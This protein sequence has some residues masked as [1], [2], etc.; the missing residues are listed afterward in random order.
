MNGI[1]TRDISVVVQGPVFGKP[2]A[3]EAERWTRRGL[4]S[5]RTFL[6]GSEII[7]STWKG[8]DATGLTY[9]VLL[10]NDDPGA[11]RYD[12]PE[13]SKL[14]NY[15]NTN[16]QIVSSR[17]G[18]KAATRPFAMKVRSDMIFRGAGFLNYWG[19]YEKRSDDWKLLESRALACTI[20]SCSPRRMN[21]YLFHPS[22]WIHFGRRDD[23]L[24]LW[25]IPLQETEAMYRYVCE[26]LVWLAFL[27]K[28]HPVPY[29]KKEEWSP[30]TA[31]L[32]ERT[33]ANNLVLLTPDQWQVVAMNRP[34]VGFKPS[35]YT[36]G[37]WLQ[38][39]NR[40][41]GG[42]ERVPLDWMALASGAVSSL[43]Q[44]KQKLR[45]ARAA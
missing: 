26:Q 37:E 17:E 44:M 33:I 11:H 2:D 4:E 40:Y 7:L 28:H 36:F 39:Y 9:D 15:N 14:A 29:E 6:P 8:A 20:F 22:D 30:E 31:N 23:T 34:D 12:N 18:L 45:G 3:P 43:T 10:E 27:R 24:N 21:R 13:G 38:I 35:V 25:D 5:L 16:R 42:T 32:S 1:S 19:R 41:C